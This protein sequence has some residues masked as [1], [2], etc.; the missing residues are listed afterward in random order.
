VPDQFNAFSAA[1]YETDHHI[2]PHDDRA[3]TPVQL[4]TGEV[5]TCSR[6]LTCVY[7]L[8][9]DWTADMGGAFVDLEADPEP[10]PSSN[11]TAGSGG[12]SSG[13]GGGG[14]MVQHPAQQRPGRVYVPEFN[15]AVFFR[16]PRY[17]R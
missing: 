12:G 3:Y 13:S 9:K 7:Y 5:I 8:T 2:A 6:D 10:G 4:D 15:S 14:S 16:V 17:H 1:R 11:G